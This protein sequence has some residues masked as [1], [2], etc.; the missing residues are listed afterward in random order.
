LFEPVGVSVVIGIAASGLDVR[1]RT[2]SAAR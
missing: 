1:K 2:S